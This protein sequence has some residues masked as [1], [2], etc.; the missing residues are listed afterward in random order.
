M[1]A[2]AKKHYHKRTTEHY[3]ILSGNGELELNDECISVGP[4]AVIVIAPPT[5]HALRGEFE[6]IN[7]VSPPFDPE[8]EYVAE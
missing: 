5:K 3:I 4:G 6:I 2:A 1:K 8:D 7:V